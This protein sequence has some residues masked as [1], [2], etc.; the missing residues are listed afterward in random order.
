MRNASQAVNFKCMLGAVY[1]FIFSSA[2]LNNLCISLGLKR[3]RPE[4]VSHLLGS[5]HSIQV[6]NQLSFHGT[7]TPVKLF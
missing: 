7:E 1:L 4:E 2:Q 6:K 5:V 3:L